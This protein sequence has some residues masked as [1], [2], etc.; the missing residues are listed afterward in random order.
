M[1]KKKLEDFLVK[2]Q[3][4]LRRSSSIFRKEE[5]DR[6]ELIFFFN[7]KSLAEELR[8]EFKERKILDIFEKGPVQKRIEEG[9]HAILK[10]CRAQAKNFKKTRGVLIKGNQHSIKVN[11]AQEVNPK[12]NKNYDNFDKLKKLYKEELDKFALDLNE[13]MKQEYNK[14]LTKTEV[15]GR[16]DK[17]ERLFKRTLEV[18][19]KEIQYGSDLIEG[20]H[21]QGEGILETDVRNAIERA[22]NK[23]Y[24]SKASEE[25]LKSN[26]NAL[27]IELH[28]VR[29]DKS[30]HHTFYMQSRVENQTLGF[31]SGEDKQKL[32]KQLKAAIERL[33]DSTPIKG[34]K[35]SDSIEQV[36]TKQAEY[37]AMSEYEKQPNLKTTKA[38]K[39]KL[40]KRAAKTSQKKAKA[41]SA[42][43][44]TLPS[45][46][47]P[48][49]VQ[50]R[51]RKKPQPK[52][53]TASSPLHLIGVL[54]KELPNTVRK[55][56]RAPAL[57]NQSG[58]FA[59][60]V[61]VTDITTTKKGFPSIGY[62]YAKN[63]YQVFED[64]SGKPP[65]ADGDRDPRVL[66]D[67]SIREIAIQFAIGRFYTRRQ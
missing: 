55:N 29:D 18:S 13:F 3:G 56:M 57:E 11:I 32:K 21:V 65:W 40:K 26:L 59:E 25:V 64:G 28:F 53:G 1:S 51:K 66:I 27:G 34:L 14:K 6:N 39:P 44:N 17:K 10:A 20:G 19:D 62:T 31:A 2:L 63:P 47:V 61:K 60:S 12:K 67:K 22:M 58:R 7:A 15:K 5:A 8:K 42:K 38:V 54:N 37:A 48:K 36:K 35:G 43:G 46:A 4:E 45:A 30:D 50:R 9:S 16:F 41:G 24:S 23:T 33:Q 49:V 52:R